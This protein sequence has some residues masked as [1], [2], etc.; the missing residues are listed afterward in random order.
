[1][2]CLTLSLCPT[3][4]E[5]FR[6]E[7]ASECQVQAPAGDGG[8]GVVAFQCVVLYSGRWYFGSWKFTQMLVVVVL[9]YREMSG[10]R[11][12]LRNRYFL[13]RISIMF[14][15]MR[16]GTRLQYE[17]GSQLSNDFRMIT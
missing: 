11:R 16:A 10:R 4:W 9:L 17:T 8:V 3:L 12:H 14:A 13:V 7:C 2:L 5:L 6:A 1:M 15:E